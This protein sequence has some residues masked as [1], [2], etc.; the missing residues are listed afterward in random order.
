MTETDIGGQKVL[1]GESIGENRLT[2]PW[3]FHF[4]VP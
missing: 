3:I 2:G 4:N 1:I